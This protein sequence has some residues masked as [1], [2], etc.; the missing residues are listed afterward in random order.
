MNSASKIKK[1]GRNIALFGILFN[2]IFVVIDLIML[3]RSEPGNWTSSLITQLVCLGVCIFAYTL[4][5]E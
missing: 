5:M 1:W 3:T 2:L 4:N